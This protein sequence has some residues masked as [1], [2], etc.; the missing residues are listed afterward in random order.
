MKQS[1]IAVSVLM[2]LAHAAP[3]RAEVT[4]SDAPLLTCVEAQNEIGARF[5]VQVYKES[6]SFGG[7]S[8]GDLYAVVTQNTSVGVNMIGIYP[9]ERKQEHGLGAPIMYTG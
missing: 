8:A 6:D 3:A 2:A 9:V 1:V 4:T 7:H 5:R